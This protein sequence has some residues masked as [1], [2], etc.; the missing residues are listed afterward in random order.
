MQEIGPAVAVVGVG[1]EVRRPVV[2]VVE[3]VASGVHDVAALAIPAWNP[4][5]GASGQFVH[6]QLAS[7]GR[8]RAEDQ[9]HRQGSGRC[10]EKLASRGHDNLQGKERSTEYV[11]GSLKPSTINHYMN[12][13]LI[14]TGHSRRFR[15]H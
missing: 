6:V 7:L 1:V 9:Q 3:A 15:V 10:N 8:R 14:C 2:V 12:L 5:P 11:M 13:S 4:L